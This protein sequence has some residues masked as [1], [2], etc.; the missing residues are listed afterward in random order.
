MPYSN[1]TWCAIWS[2]TYRGKV[3]NTIGSYA[4]MNLLVRSDY[5]FS[6]T[7]D[8]NLFFIEG[9]S[10]LKYQCGMSGALPLGYVDAAL[11]P[12]TT[13]ANIPAMIERNSKSIA[14]L[15]S[16]LPVLQ[17]IINRQWSKTDEL[18][19]LKAECHELQTKIEAELHETGQPLPTTE[20]EDA[21]VT[22]VAA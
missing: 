15:E 20:T 18:A 1:R 5:N 13:L 19:K 9:V 8:R 16:E 6:G 3:L 11:Y 4:D 14:K 2:K 7:F 10:G 17:E 12:K 22:D 21:A